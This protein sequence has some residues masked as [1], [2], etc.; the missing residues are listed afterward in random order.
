MAESSGNIEALVRDHYREV[1][2]LLWA[3][4]RNQ[5]TADELTQE[6]FIVALKRGMAPGEGM[7]LWLRETARRLAM[8]EMRRKRPAPLV[9]R[10]LAELPGLTVVAE[11]GRVESFEDELTALRDCLAD[12][13]EAD[14][15]L[16][17]ERYHSGTSIAE[18]AEKTGT[19]V[20]YL[21]LKLFRLRK[22][23]GERIKR[24]VAGSLT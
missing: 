3:L 13:P 5:H 12:L 9:P 10:D 16:L 8:N 14:R 21:K 23:L 2:G 18:L 4:T 19:S 17:S 22:T 24:K 11:S 20:E 15:E 7:R 6:V 1:H